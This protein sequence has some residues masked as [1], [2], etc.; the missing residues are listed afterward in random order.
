MIY[1]M[2][3]VETLGKCLVAQHNI[4]SAMFKGKETFKTSSNRASVHKLLY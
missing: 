4:M 1:V 2:Y 3:D